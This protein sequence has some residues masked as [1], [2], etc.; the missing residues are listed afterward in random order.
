MVPLSL[1]VY[2]TSFTNMCFIIGQ[3]IAA[4][5]L[6]GLINNT[7]QWA[8]R[9]P[10]AIQWVWPAVL[11]PVLLFAPD[12]PWWL[13]RKGRL[14]D[15]EKSVL[16]LSSKA[17]RA[18]AKQ[19]VAFMVH[20]NN[21][22]IELSA[23]TSY[24]QCFRGVDLRRTEIACISFAGQIFSGLQFAYSATYFFQ[25]IGVSSGSSYK[26]N[27]GSTALALFGTL[28]S[29]FCVMPYV[30]RRMT[31]L[32][33]IVAMTVI[34][35]I[36]GF[37]D[38]DSSNKQASTAQAALTL[39]WTLV[40]QLSVGQLGWAIPS[41]ISSTRLRQK[42]VVIARNSYNIVGIVGGVLEP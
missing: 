4:G 32:V 19:T 23:G 28:L 8:Y 7:T 10:F 34:L 6:E 21:L 13:V 37:L 35:F 36:I 42:T 26:L 12:S 33:G 18:N 11:F 15:A 17:T 16:R 1:R 27:V 41:E 29:W 30:G 5:V 40:F 25:Q 2:L 9:I 20:T 24:L 39:L 22:E 3:L 38:L 14:D 31:Y